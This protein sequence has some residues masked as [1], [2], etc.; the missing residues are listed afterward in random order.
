VGRRFGQ[1]FLADSAILRRIAEAACPAPV[2]LVV[3]AGPGKGAL[4]AP[5]LERA[6]KVVAI[7][8]DPVLVYYL[9]Q[10]FKEPIESGRLILVEG[11]ILKTDLAA[12]GNCVIAGNVPYYI[13]SPI[14]ERV[15]AARGSWQRAVLLVQAEVA[16]RLTASPGNRDYGY[17]SVFTQVQARVQ[18]L[19]EVPRGAFRPPPRV[20]SALVQLEP[21]N[22]EVLDLDRFLVF[23]G[24]CFRQKRKTL[25]NNLIPI[26]GKERVESLIDARVRAEQLS[27]GALS[28]LWEKLKVP[29]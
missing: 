12:W 17:L 22:P 15:F 18:R 5:L 2:P 7:E 14:L 4:T 28:A 23:A 29:S 20:H 3:E 24:E 21:R 1:H 10:R 11:D 13:S 19:L 16:E 27:V 6:G 8:V 9:R 26:Y 25:R